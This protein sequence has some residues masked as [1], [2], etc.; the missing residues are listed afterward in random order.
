MQSALNVFG[1]QNSSYD[2]W[3]RWSV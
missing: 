3:Q 1:K 2:D